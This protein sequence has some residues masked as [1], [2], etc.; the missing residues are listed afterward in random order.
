[1]RVFRVG[2]LAVVA[3][4]LLVEAVSGALGEQELPGAPVP[5]PPAVRLLYAP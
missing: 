1:M 2:A 4:V 5:R 3:L